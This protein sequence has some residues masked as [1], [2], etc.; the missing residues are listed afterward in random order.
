MNHIVAS[1][2]A[3]FANPA[4][5]KAYS[6]LA[7]HCMTRIVSSMEYMI[8]A[9][10]RAARSSEGG[11]DERNAADEDARSALDI[12]EMLGFAKRLSPQEEINALFAVWQ[13]AADLAN[14]RAA[15]DR[16]SK[17]MTIKHYLLFL[18][19]AKAKVNQARVDQICEV[20]G[21]DRKTAEAEAM[22]TKLDEQK[23]FAAI[24]PDLLSRWES[25]S[26]EAD[27]ED[28]LDALPPVHLI[29]GLVKVG[30]RLSKE[31]AKFR[32]WAIAGSD[33]ALS[34]A[35]LLKDAVDTTRSLCAKLEQHHADALSDA[36]ET[37][38]WIGSASDI[39]DTA[40]KLK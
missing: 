39:K 7:N 18:H 9:D 17:P 33:D 28:A 3:Q 30:Q 19:D 35:A 4:D 16:Y 23:A 10:A 22:A 20:L 5:A 8:R 26:S 13:A 37:G 34:T 38:A 15:G 12:H 27:L 32:Q 6:F 11:I 1:A 25:L 24:I 2:F 31:C 21:M 14:K 36:A 40:I 29:N